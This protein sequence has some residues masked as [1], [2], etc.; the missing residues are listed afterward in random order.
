MRKVKKAKKDSVHL[1]LDQLPHG[2]TLDNIQVFPEVSPNPVSKNGEPLF[3]M[4]NQ[5][6]FPNSPFIIK[7][8]H[9]RAQ[10]LKALIES[11]NHDEDEGH[12]NDPTLNMN[13][14]TDYKS[15]VHYGDE[16]LDWDTP[17]AQDYESSSDDSTGNELVAT[18]GIGCL[19]LTP[20]SS[21]R[22]SSAARTL[23]SPT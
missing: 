8:R 16:P 2:R 7:M 13:H 4:A 17:S 15:Q 23:H 5:N 21:Q 12:F 10:Y 11:L 22:L 20:A 9:P 6:V 19:S 18:A 3:I 1:P 14:H